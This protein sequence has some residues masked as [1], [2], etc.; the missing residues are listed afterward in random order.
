MSEYEIE[1]LDATHKHLEFSE[2]NVLGSLGDTVCWTP[3]Y[4]AWK[5]RDPFT[6]NNCVS[7]A[8]LLPTGIGKDDG[9]LLISFSADDVIQIHVRWPEVPN[10]HY[11][12]TKCGLQARTYLTSNTTTHVFKSYQESIETLATVVD[13]R[14]RLLLA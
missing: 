14:R 11:F 8:I 2:I 7:V 13:G 6:S 5:W 12:S 10:N 1:P 3:M 4:H 9:Q